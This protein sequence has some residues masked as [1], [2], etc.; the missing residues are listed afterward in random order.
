MRLIMWYGSF[1]RVRAKSEDRRAGDFSSMTEKGD[2]EAYQDVV[3]EPLNETGNQ[4]SQIVRGLWRT[5]SAKDPGPPPDGGVIA[6]SQ[7]LVGHLV[8]LNTW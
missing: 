2:V 6:W 8:V 4:R 3:N 7:V 5:K 1:I